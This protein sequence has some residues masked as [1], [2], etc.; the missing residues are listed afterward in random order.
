MAKT[1][2][3]EATKPLPVTKII[4][5]AILI[6][7]QKRVRMLQAL[8]LPL[9][10]L[11]AMAA[12]SSYLEQGSGW[13]LQ[14]AFTIVYILIFTVFAVI[15]HR[16]VLLGD[17]AVPTYG[18]SKWTRRET[19]FSGWL[20]GIYLIFTVVA[21]LIGAIGLTLIWNLIEGFEE[22]FYWIMWIL[23]APGLYVFARL[24]L[25]LPATAID[26]R[27]NLAWSWGLSSNNGWR[28]VIVVGVLPWLMA[29]L[30]WL[31]LRDNASIVEIVIVALL[32]YALLTV[33][34]AALS[35]SYREL[36]QNVPTE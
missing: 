11:A 33:E 14:L 22:S 21:M 23:S 5:G 30:Q 27:P 16:L 35:L 29:M 7:W 3:P 34:I 28:L 1:R 4:L 15:C 9:T 8:I 6:P 24:S 26:N 2:I 10:G 32:G 20:L 18:F 12:L 19:R 36:S 17:D 31:L 25:V 13:S